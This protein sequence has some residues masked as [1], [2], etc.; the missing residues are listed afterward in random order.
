MNKRL[1][2]VYAALAVLAGLSYWQ[3]RDYL[4]STPLGYIVVSNLTLNYVL[5]ACIA[6]GLVGWLSWN[7][8][9]RRLRT[10]PRLALT[11][12]AALFASG[13]WLVL[14]SAGGYEIR[15]H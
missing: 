3:T 8:L 1:I 13:L 11:L 4:W 12:V 15:W 6:G 7:R 5:T 14:V 10:A 9:F 2:A